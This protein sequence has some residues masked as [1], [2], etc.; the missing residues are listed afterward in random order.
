LSFWKLLL[1]CMAHLHDHNNSTYF[2]H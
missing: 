1:V 2:S